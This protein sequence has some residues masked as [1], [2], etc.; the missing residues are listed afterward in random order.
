MPRGDDLGAIARVPAHCTSSA[1][2][3]TGPAADPPEGRSTTRCRVKI[4]SRAAL[5]FSGGLV[6]CGIAAVVFG[7]SLWSGTIAD[8]G[9]GKSGGPSQHH[10][11]DPPTPAP[12]PPTPPVP[13]P[14]PP[15]PVPP[16]FDHHSTVPTLGSQGCKLAQPSDW[17]APAGSSVD[18][19]LVVNG[20]TRSFR[21]HV[22]KTYEATRPVALVL[23]FHAYYDSSL[24]ME[25]RTGFSDMAE[26]ENFIVVYPQGLGDINAEAAGDD[27]T[28]GWQSWN[29]GGCSQSPGPLGETCLQWKDGNDYW[30]GTESL[31]YKSCEDVT[32]APGH[33]EGVG[34]ARKWITSGCNCCSCADDIGFVRALLSKLQSDLCVDRRRV[35]AAGF[36]Y[37]AMF[38][39][40][41]AQAT[42]PLLLSAVVS[43]AG[44][45][46]KG[47]HEPMQPTAT[48]AIAVMDVHGTMDDQVPTNSSAT[49]EEG[50]WPTSYDGWMY[51]PMDDVLTAHAH[52]SGCIEPSAAGAPRWDTPWSTGGTQYRSYDALSCTASTRGCRNN[53]EIVRCVGEWNHIWPP[54]F[55]TSLAWGF[56]WRHARVDG[57]PAPPVHMSEEHYSGRREAV[58]P[59]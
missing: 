39:L 53:T 26:D 16:R 5:V 27:G 22:P 51:T 29:G 50:K 38:S 59:L 44:G 52:Y 56:M 45:L 23:V 40:A 57:L 36:S 47:F 13:P 33:W 10:S 8:K 15:A 25:E 41:L 19:P 4:R 12:A 48:S 42:P 34:S 28:P 9:G 1:A 35:Y 46:L 37:G 55:M 17:W 3:S 14:V 49:G 7:P 21:L 6:L 20:A 18:H 32:K 11:H 31:H 54:R 24:D 30:Y 2:D 43:V 58:G